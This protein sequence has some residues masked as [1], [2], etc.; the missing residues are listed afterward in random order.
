MLSYLIHPRSGILSQI[1]S[2]AFL[3]I[4]P[5]SKGHSLIIPKCKYSTCRSFF[6]LI[7]SLDHAEKIHELP[8]QYMT[9]IL[10]L[11]KKIAIAQGLENYNILQNNG[12][13]AHQVRNS[14]GVM[15]S[16]ILLSHFVG[17]PPC[18]FSCYSQAFDE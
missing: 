7:T 8:D 16:S 3:D 2:L 6:V 14:G 10:P 13:I 9:D 15:S 1:F 12:R 17:S 4:N 18:T 11:A 5:L